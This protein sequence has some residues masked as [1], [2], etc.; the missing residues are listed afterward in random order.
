MHQIMLRRAESGVNVLAGARRLE[1]QLLANG[2]ATANLDV[3]EVT[4]GRDREGTL[5]SLAEAANDLE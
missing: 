5:A 2:R 3:L 1:A 4:I